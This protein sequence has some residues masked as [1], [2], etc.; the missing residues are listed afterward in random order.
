MENFIPGVSSGGD[1]RLLEIGS[2]DI[3]LLCLGQ[4][5]DTG[6]PQVGILDTWVPIY[7]NGNGLSR[8]G[9][10]INMEMD[11]LKPLKSHPPKNPVLPTRMSWAALTS[12]SVCP[13]V[14]VNGLGPI[15]PR[16]NW[17]LVCG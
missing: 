6:Q 13:P 7:L 11:P 2:L 3:T 5:V 12:W 15:G 9:D 1:S 10:Y 17:A 8:E 14:H 16:L 4:V